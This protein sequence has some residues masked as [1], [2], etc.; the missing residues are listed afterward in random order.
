MKGKPD[1]LKKNDKLHIPI[2]S[3]L[4]E[5]L[6]QRALDCGMTLSQYCLFILSQTKPK[7]E[8]IPN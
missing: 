5:K 1:N 8:F 2:S 7:V 6:K 3:E 4:K